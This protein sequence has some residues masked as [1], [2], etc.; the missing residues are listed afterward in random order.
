M[1]AKM[2]VSLDPTNTYRASMP[3]AMPRACV[4]SR[5]CSVSSQPSATLQ[6]RLVPSAETPT[7]GAVLVWP[8][9]L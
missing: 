5:I 8:V 2:A 3:G 4:M 7:T 9:F 1:A 6:S